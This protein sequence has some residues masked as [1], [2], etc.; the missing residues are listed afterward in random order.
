M[1]HKFEK[2]CE[3]RQNEIRAGSVLG[4]VTKRIAVITPHRAL[5][6]LRFLLNSPRKTACCWPKSAI[7][8]HSIDSIRS[9]ET[10]EICGLGAIS[11]RSCFSTSLYRS[12]HPATAKR[13]AGR[14]T[15]SAG[16]SLLMPRPEVTAHPATAKRKAG[17]PRRPDAEQGRQVT[18]CSCRTR[19]SRPT[20]RRRA[21]VFF[22]T[23]PSSP[24][25]PNRQRL[26]RIRKGDSR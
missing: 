10:G 11:E 14:G 6:V 8:P 5:V 16:H 21:R 15:K 12:S 4:H 25:L 17:G 22:K 18:R 23:S 19:R 26:T 20:P 1:S 3:A 2:R 7:H 9:A 13:K 24:Q